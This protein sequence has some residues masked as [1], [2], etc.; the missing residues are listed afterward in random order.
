[1][2][3]TP[4]LV[5]SSLERGEDIRR[6]LQKLIIEYGSITTHHHSQTVPDVRRCTKVSFAAFR[7]VGGNVFVKFHFQTKANFCKFYTLENVLGLIVSTEAQQD[8]GHHFWF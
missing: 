3:L 1:M 7:P 4:Y 6:R 2:D 5:R 8:S